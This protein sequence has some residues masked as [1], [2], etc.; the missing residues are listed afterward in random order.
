[1]GIHHTDHTDHLPDVRRFVPTM[2]VPL[3]GNPR[4][5]VGHSTRGLPSHCLPPPT[6]PQH[7]SSTT[8]VTP[9]TYPYTMVGVHRTPL[10]RFSK[11]DCSTTKRVPIP[12]HT[13][14]ECS[15]RGVFNAEHFWH[16][17]SSNYGDII[18]SLQVTIKMNL[19]GRA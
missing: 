4:A 6:S 17:P 19:F 1:M 10:G 16:R 7:S 15:R 12:N 11:L 5:S 14:S 3:G 13:S 2:W 9:D 18:H 8:A